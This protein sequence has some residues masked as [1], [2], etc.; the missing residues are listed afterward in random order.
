MAISSLGKVGCRSPE[1]TSSQPTAMGGHMGK[2]PVKKNKK[3]RESSF[4]LNAPETLR[5]LQ[6]V[7]YYLV[8][9]FEKCSK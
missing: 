3:M 5:L 7:T 9:K 2:C 6:L 1:M 8:L 4:L